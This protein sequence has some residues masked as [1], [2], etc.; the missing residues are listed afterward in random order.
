MLSLPRFLL[1]TLGPAALAIVYVAISTLGLGLYGHALF[2]FLPFVMTAF[3]IATLGWR[4]RPRIWEFPVAWFA[5]VGST[6]V[7]LLGVGLEGLI[8]LAMA[9]GLVAIVAVPIIAVSI[10]ASHFLVATEA[11]S[12]CGSSTAAAIFALL[13]PLLTAMEYRIGIPESIFQTSTSIIVAAPREVV[14]RH[15][16][17]FS[18]I[19][20]EPAWYF[21]K[22]IAYP[23]RAR[24]EGTGVGAVRY[25]EFS[26]GPF[27]EPITVWDE[28]AHLA[29]SVESSPPA[30]TELNPF[31]NVAPP[32]IHDYFKS[33]RGEFRLEELPGG[34][35]LLTG[36]T[37]YS[38]RIA[39][40]WYWNLWTKHLLH[41]IHTR[42]LMHVKGLAEAEG[43][44]AG[45]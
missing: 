27:V 21:R 39:P 32:H 15:V 9:L 7:G 2:I 29:F 5:M 38:H 22:G 37:W 8:C 40:S 45:E 28:P 20:G 6:G 30:M 16:V 1:A 11:K 35:T 43:A 36:T 26:T 13:L 14:W 42:V 3:M 4:R 31:R 25:C 34:K 44:G 12:G 23:L 24:I 10:I 33:H 17:S 41:D 18:D 19:S